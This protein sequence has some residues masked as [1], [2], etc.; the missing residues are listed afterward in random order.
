MHRDGASLVE[1]ELIHSVQPLSPALIGQFYSLKL[2]DVVPEIKHSWVS[3]QLLS[4]YFC[5]VLVRF[6]WREM[7]AN[8]PALGVGGAFARIA[9][10]KILAA[11]KRNRI[12]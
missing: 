5:K 3:S 1:I 6:G 10:T 7:A 11:R 12:R 2:S 4:T 9:A 8:D